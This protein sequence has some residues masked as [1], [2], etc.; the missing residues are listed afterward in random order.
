MKTIN[1]NNIDNKLIEKKKSKFSKFFNFIKQLFMKNKYSNCNND[2]NYVSDREEDKNKFLEDIYFYID[3]KI[4][5]LKIKLD[6]GEIQAIDLLDEEI[7]KLQIIYDRE[8][9]E[10]RDRIIKLKRVLNLN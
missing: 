5:S 2:L 7:D 9:K 4:K 1:E 3:D 10:R 6:K 8:I